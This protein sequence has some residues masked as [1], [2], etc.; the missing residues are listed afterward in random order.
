VRQ[1]ALSRIDTTGQDSAKVDADKL[2]CWQKADASRIS[3]REITDFAHL[4]NARHALFLLDA[5]YGGLTLRDVGV[6]SKQPGYV[7]ELMRKPVRQV[8]TAGGKDERVIE[9]GGHGLF[10][11]FLLRALEKGEADDGDGDLL[12]V[13]P[14]TRRAALP[15]AAAPPKMQRRPPQLGRGRGAARRA[16]GPGAREKIEGRWHTCSCP[17]RSP[18]DWP[19]SRPPRRRSSSSYS[20][21]PR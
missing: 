20:S 10:T 14:G 5:C 4:I 7:A 9:E 8:I 17:S 16:R 15:P 13:R 18:I 11:K 3:M 1:S 6:T 12:F 21:A 19:I 2:A